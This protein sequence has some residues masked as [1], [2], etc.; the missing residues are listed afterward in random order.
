MRILI[1]DITK[2]YEKFLE[3]H[4]KGTFLGASEIG[5]A[6]GQ[7]PF[8]TPLQLWM[9]KTGRD[10]SVIDNVATRRGKVLERAVADIFLEENTKFKS[11]QKCPCMYQHNTVDWAVASPDFGVYEES[12]EIQNE[13]LWGPIGFVGN[14]LETKTTGYWAAA[15]WA[16]GAIPNSAFCQVQWQL[17]VLG[18]SVGYIAVLIAGRDF[19][20]RR[21]EFSKDVFEQ[22]LELGDKFLEMVKADVPPGAQ[23]NDD[24]SLLYKLSEKQ[25]DLGGNN[26]LCVAATQYAGSLLRLK[27]ANK[28]AKEIEKERD[29]LKNTVL[30]A[31]GEAKIARL[32]DLTVERKETYVEEKSPRKYWRRSLVVSGLETEEE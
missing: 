29:G 22:L 19:H 23:W 6:A 32:G 31:M 27:E 24:L 9:R 18:H 14:P 5:T 16:D 8:Q 10:V 2:D 17:G 30:Q 11:A 25:I 7:N 28:K 21:V 15:D 12:Y 1:P 20:W 26:E 4:G 13:A 3:V